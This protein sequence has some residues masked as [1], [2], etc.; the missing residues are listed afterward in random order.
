MAYDKSCL[1][2]IKLHRQL[3]CLQQISFIKNP[4]S[5]GSQLRRPHGTRPPSVPRLRNK[6]DGGE[7]G[8]SPGR[9]VCRSR[10]ERGAL[11]ARNVSPAPSSIPS[12][13][14]RPLGRWSR[15][16]SPAAAFLRAYLSRRAIITSFPSS[17]WP[18]W[19]PPPRESPAGYRTALC[20]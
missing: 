1:Q 17:P 10:V 20:A 13:S 18:S 12:P 15:A 3:S 19:G 5:G 7:G 16:A 9:S 4:T 6:G 8:W 2:N 14:H 11:S